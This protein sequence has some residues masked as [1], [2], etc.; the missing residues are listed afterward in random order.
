M[1]TYLLHELRAPVAVSGGD[2][3]LGVGA[4]RRS[5]VNAAARAMQAGAIADKR[6]YARCPHCHR[7]QSWMKSSGHRKNLLS[8]SAVHIGIAAASNPKVRYG[9]YWTLILAEPRRR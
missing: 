2:A 9:T 1:F 3:A 6:G 7:Y 4:M 8:R 5:A